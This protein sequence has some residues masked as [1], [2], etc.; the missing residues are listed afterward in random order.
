MTSPSRRHP[1]RRLSTL[2]VASSSHSSVESFELR[3]QIALS[4]GASPPAHNTRARRSSEHHPLNDSASHLQPLAQNMASSSVI[5]YEIGLLV[6]QALDKVGDLVSLNIDRFSLHTT[7][8]RSNP[9]SFDMVAVHSTLN[10][11]LGEAFAV[12]RAAG[13]GPNAIE[14]HRGNGATVQVDS[15]STVNPVATNLTRRQIQEIGAK[16]GRDPATLAEVVRRMWHTGSRCPDVTPVV[17][18]HCNLLIA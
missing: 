9:D 15:A 12:Y 2:S 5:E 4:T 7:L 11:A 13:S 6:T 14:S 16:F 1:S 10:H 8:A 17:T 18:R 3:S